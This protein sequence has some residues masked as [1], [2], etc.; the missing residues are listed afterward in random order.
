[1][2]DKD[3]L[4]DSSPIRL[5]GISRADL[6]EHSGAANLIV[7]TD[8]TILAVNV[9]FETVTGYSRSE[10]EGTL[11]WRDL[12]HP[13]D[14]ERMEE[15]HRLRRVDPELVPA[16]YEYRF[17][18]SVGQVRWG[19][20]TGATLADDSRT[21]LSVVDITELKEK[22][23][24]LGRAEELYRGIVQT[25]TELISRFT[26]DFTLTFVNDAYCRYF[27]E[28]REQLVG[29]S[30]VHHVL[31]EDLAD[32]RAY[33][34]LLTPERPENEMEERAI[35]S[36][37]EVR[38]QRWHDRGIFDEKGNLIEI[39]SIGR[40]ITD[41]YLTREKLDSTIEK[42]KN[43]FARAIEMAGKIIEVRD[44]FTAG[45][46]RRV[47]RIAKE[48]ASTLGLSRNEVTAIEL[49][50]LAHDVGKIHVPSE[51]LSKPGVLQP[52]EWSI[53]RQHPVYSAEIL[54][55]LVTPWEL[56]DIALQHHERYDGSGYPQG[57]SGQEIR[58]EARVISVADVIEAMSSHRPY[59]PG[60]GIEKALEEVEAGRGTLFDPAAADSALYIF[61]K[62]GFEI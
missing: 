55:T 54:K 19:L 40:D 48:M 28:T 38:W 61:R 10:V 5:E 26:P 17:I 29:S 36:S 32:Q 33:F 56:A 42:L 53:I 47:A 24:A 31:P 9:M 52:T 59:R 4:Y 14:R 44:P 49:A 27:G 1:M 6:F 16:N 20:L 12:V 3:Q 22:E 7:D 60:V 23:S 11:S 35:L 51:I 2:T 57:L 41:L 45:H 34:A 13:E 58:I 50:A 8:T 43:S 15:Y 30:F 39:Q 18:T 46:Q 62:K 37:G 21:L 25:Q